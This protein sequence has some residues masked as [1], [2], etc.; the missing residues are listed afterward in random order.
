MQTTSSRAAA[1]QIAGLTFRVIAVCGRWVGMTIAAAAPDLF[2]FV[3]AGLMAYGAWLIF[4][5]VGFL[6]GGLFFLV[7]GGVGI[8]RRG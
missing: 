7:V 5:P 8:W 2:A 3:G 4:K 1:R 6:V